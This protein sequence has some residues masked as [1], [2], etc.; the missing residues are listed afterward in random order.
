MSILWSSAAR[1]AQVIPCVLI[2]GLP[3]I[4]VPEGVTLTGWTA[5]ALDAAW[6]PGSSFSGF[7]AFIKPWLSLLDGIA[8]EEKAEPVQPEMLNISSVT[9]GVSDV[10]LRADGTS[11]LATA[12]F[13]SRDSVDVSWI[14]ADVSTTATTV[15]VAD[16]TGFAASGYI[17]VG[18]ETMEYTSK[19]G[20]SFSVGTAAN[21]GKF[22]S[23]K[24][25]HWY[26]GNGNAAIANPEVTSGA[27]EI[28]GR[29]ITLWLLQVSP[30]GVVTAGTLAFYGTIGTGVMLSET[31][32]T[33][34]IRADHAVKRLGAPLRG[35]TV[36]VGGFVHTGPENARGVAAT[37]VQ[38]FR[39]WAP[40]VD[41]WKN[42]TNDLV[43]INTL[44]VAAAAPDNGGWHATAEDY[45]QAL[46]VAAAALWP[47][48]DVVRYELVGDKLRIFA[49]YNAASYTLTLAWVWDRAGEGGIA[50]PFDGA[51]DYTSGKSFPRAW[52]PIMAT[53]RVYLTAA[54][55]ALIPAVPS[56]GLGSVYYV[57]AFG[58][59][60]DARYARITGR[61]SSGGLYWIEVSAITR[62][63][64]QMDALGVS[65]TGFILTEPTAA[66]I[67][68]EV[69]A[70]TWVDALEALITAFDTSLA[71]TNADLFDFADMRS[72]AAQ[73][74]AGPFARN[75][76]YIVDLTETLIDLVTNECR[77]NGFT[78]VIKGGRITIARISDFAPT[79][80][81]AATITTAD[82]H[83]DH[84]VPGY[85]RGF[86]GIINAM[87]F[88]SPQTGITVN[89]VDAT[90]TTR[91][92]AGRSTIEAVA[93][94]QITGDAVNL[95]ASYLELARQAATVLG[96][97]RYPYEH[98]TLTTTPAL[99][100]LQV[101]A[102]VRLD[103]WRV[104]DQHGA[105]G[106]VRTGQVMARSWQLYG[107]AVAALMHTVR[108]SP[109]RIA[110][111]SPAVL[112]AAGGIT[113]AD[114]TADTT[115]F[116]A[117]GFA[118]S[119]STGGVD[120]F[121]VGDAVRLV[122][123][124]A[125]SPTASTAHTVGAVS[126]SV[127]T[128]SPA[129]NATFVTLSASALKVMIVPDDWG[130]SITAAQQEYAY[131]AAATYRLDA[132]TR[133]RTYAP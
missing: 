50:G 59:G 46:N 3:V 131:L 65:G 103:L 111:W 68:C 71:E 127:I 40:T 1:G 70:A 79:E 84:P 37:D 42:A 89:V 80:P 123:I 125:T 74:P 102:V 76:T 110:G 44:T 91:Y 100:N 73:Y 124:G 32:E 31:G 97:L 116:G 98:V 95:A 119:G 18:R 29:T 58:D 34:T 92:G 113:G 78:L 7:S 72:V 25:H 10:G 77:L 14:T 53:S 107:G 9:I 75:R 21:R 67:A 82:L 38:F 115:T 19:T 20:T 36:S 87:R 57:L 13:A 61:S 122:E 112:V 114:V 39:A 69:S 45:V 47:A 85:A 133:A 55:Y 129:P 4:L 16:T 27:P 12:L 54:D 63:Q 104:P 2:A 101:G 62:D 105:R 30:A 26:T 117:A 86:D 51:H 109:A 93:P 17:Y 99:A 33:W 8:W 35:D 60:Q 49:A 23:P 108:L 121:E 88:S 15:S 43:A 41:A 83:I 126:G 90:S 66:R 28:I 48:P 106:I 130:T 94:R 52:V 96:P 22:G 64:A 11:G 128:L 6:W 120:Y 118:P 24:Q 56:S 132:S 81:A 5:G